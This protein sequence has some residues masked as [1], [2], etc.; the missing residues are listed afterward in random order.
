MKIQTIEINNYKAFHGKYNINVGGKN[1]FIYGENG[2]G[3]SSLYYALKD[4]FQASIENINLNELENIF[5]PDSKKG[6]A[7]IKVSFKPNKD[8]QKTRKQYQ[9]SGT[10]N[11]TRVVGDTSIRDA[12]KLKSFLTYKHLLSIHHSKKD[13]DI[14]LFDLLVNGVLKHFK[15]SLTNGKELGELWHEVEEVISRKPGKEYRSDRKRTD[16]N[17]A[18]KAFNDAFSELFK[19]E[20]PEYIL[21]HAAPI[22]ERFKHNIELKLHFPQVR[23]IEEYSALADHNVSI[24]LKYAGKTVTYPHL[25][26]NEARLSAI[27]IS[28]YLGMIKRHVQGI[29]CKILFL[30]DIF[31][32]LDIANR[33][34]LLEILKSEFPDYQIFITTYDKPW[35]EYAKSFLE[36]QPGWKTMEFYAQLTDKGF[37]IPCI[38]DDQDLLTRAVAHHGNSDYKAAAVY[39]R[40]AF[41]KL[42]QKACE[43]K[44]K[45]IIFRSRLKDYTTEH[46]WN[47]LKVDLQPATI[48]D[49]ERYRSLV[50]NTFSHYNTEKHEIGPE[51]TSAIQAI[52][53]LK[54]ELSTL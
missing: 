50:L 19:E 27:T 28:I 37:E 9:F 33:L 23:P 10:V 3:K 4:F 21:K 5:L 34:P 30:D 8:G 54:L 12:N 42:I 48:A 38:F 51:L 26:L 13:D 41:E 2:S 7:G 46:F 22:L 40:S 1:L 18:I 11:E 53:T 47:A 32:G 31:I 16:A 6:N 45:K 20:S 15:Y 36:G 17:A 24:Q 14:N 43:K 35:F 29:P 52:K 49:I 44:D 25:F 39:T